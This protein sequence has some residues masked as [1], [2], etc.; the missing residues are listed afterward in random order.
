M[1]Y[2]KY[3]VPILILGLLS[4]NYIHIFYTIAILSIIK[5][6]FEFI[7]GVDSFG[8]ADIIVFSGISAFFDLNSL[9]IIFTLTTILPIFIYLLLITNKNNRKDKEIKYIPMIP[10]LTLSIFITIILNN[11]QKID[12]INSFF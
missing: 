10:V 7:K 5:Y 3:T 11:F 8:E 4:F 1:I 2:D 12:I 6:I 9:I